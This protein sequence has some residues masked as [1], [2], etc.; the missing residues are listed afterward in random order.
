MSNVWIGHV[1]IDHLISDE[2]LVEEYDL[3]WDSVITSLGCRGAQK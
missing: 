1:G 2:H 3:A